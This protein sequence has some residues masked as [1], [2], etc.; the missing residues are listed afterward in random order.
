[1]KNLLTLFLLFLSITVFCQK[2]PFQGRLLDDGR[3]FNGT[4]SVDF[5]IDNRDR[6]WDIACSERVRHFSLVWIYS[7]GVHHQIKWKCSQKLNAYSVMKLVMVSGEDM[8]EWEGDE[9]STHSR[10]SLYPLLNFCFS[11]RGA[12]VCFTSP[13]ERRMHRYAYPQSWV[14]R[15]CEPFKL[16]VMKVIKR[17]SAY[18]ERWQYHS[19]HV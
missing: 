1:M 18:A 13:W 3:P 19:L 8:M 2:I 15:T 17:V 11:S 9:L 5:S 12:P 6:E 7:L 16:T 10:D 4:A 14:W